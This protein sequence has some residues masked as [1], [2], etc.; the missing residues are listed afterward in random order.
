MQHRSL[1]G[2]MSAMRTR[3]K[4]DA[5]LYLLAEDRILCLTYWQK[6]D[7]CPDMVVELSLIHI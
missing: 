2:G 4:E 7:S 5:C 1:D 3:E 6:T